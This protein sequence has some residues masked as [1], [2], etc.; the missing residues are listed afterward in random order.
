MKKAIGGRGKNSRLI[1][2]PLAPEE[3]EP[4]YKNGNR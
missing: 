3:I 4:A 2:I 1:G